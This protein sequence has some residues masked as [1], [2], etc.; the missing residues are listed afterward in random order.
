MWV[1][2]VFMQDTFR[3]FEFDTKEEAVVAIQQIEEPAILSFTNW[4]LAA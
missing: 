2:T 3:M 4:T 1:I